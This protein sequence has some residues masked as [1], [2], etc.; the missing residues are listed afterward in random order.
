MKQKLSFGLSVSHL[1]YNKNMAIQA[2]E[3]SMTDIDIEHVE[4]KTL[5]NGNMFWTEHSMDIVTVGYIE[6]RDLL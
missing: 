2:V 1:V 3:Q 6:V 4:K 5:P